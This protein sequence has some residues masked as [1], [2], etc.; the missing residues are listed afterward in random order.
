LCFSLQEPIQPFKLAIQH[1]VFPFGVFIF[2]FD[3]AQIID[4]G[5]VSGDFMFIVLDCSGVAL[6][7]VLQVTV[8]PLDDSVVF[9]GDLELRN[10][11]FP[12]IDLSQ[13]LFK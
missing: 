12:V 13:T 10:F 1:T 7:F 3:N 2:L 8:V 9:Y 11:A 4:I 6:D 5:F